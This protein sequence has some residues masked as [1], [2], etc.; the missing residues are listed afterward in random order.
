MCGGYGYCGIPRHSSGQT[1][2]CGYPGLISQAHASVRT[3]EGVARRHALA[4]AGDLY[5][6][7]QRFLAHVCEPELHA[8]A[9][10][11]GRAMSE[12]A[13]MPVSLASAAWSSAVSHCAA[14]HYDDAIRL[15]AR[16]VDIVRPIVGLP[17]A[18][19]VFG[20]LQLEAAAAYALAGRCW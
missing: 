17:E 10:E 11:R 8:L 5:R 9:V 4:A 7:V 12:E 16:G 19:G 13:D 14:G 6:L 18:A 1:L 15:A 20:A 2:A 3:S